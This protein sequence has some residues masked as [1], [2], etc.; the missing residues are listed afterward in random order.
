ME[1]LLLPVVVE[2]INSLKDG[3]V[4]IKISTQ[5]LTPSKAG[6]VFEL[7]NKLCAAYFSTKETISQK[8]LAQVDALQPEMQGKTPSQRLRGVLYRLWEQEPEGY[9]DFAMYYQVKLEKIITHYKN[10]LEK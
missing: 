3:S 4:S 6:Q 1:G 7:R 10:E 8:E 9:K 5:E 2:S